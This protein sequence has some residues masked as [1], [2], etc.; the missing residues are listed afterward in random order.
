M[1]GMDEQVFKAL[2]DPTRRELLDRLYERDGQSLGELGAAFEMSRFGV[3]KHLR[4]LEDANL[5]TTQKVG[6]SRLHYL[7]PVPIRELHDRWIGKYAAAA[8]AALLGLKAD[9]EKG[10]AMAAMVEPTLADAP[11]GETIPS[12][13]FAVF[14]KATAERI[15]EA[16]TSS[17]FTTKYYFAST[18]ESDWTPGAPYTYRIEGKPAVVGEVIEAQPPERL[19]CSFDARWDEEVAPDAPSRITWTIEQAGPDVCKL[20]V[21]HDG[22]VARNATYTQVGEGMTLILSGLKTLL[23]T[24]KPLMSAA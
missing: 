16:I 5:V 18:V 8:S 22:F 13:V 4:L 23:E 20:T 15:W 17:E 11:A 1:M 10:A 3:M 19:V 14:V 6:R 12:H 2:S 9:L 21:V 7:N 24:G